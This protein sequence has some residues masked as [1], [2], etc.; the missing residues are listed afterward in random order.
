MKKLHS[1][2]TS[3][4]WRR[5]FALLCGGLIC[6]TLWAEAEQTE[7]AGKVIRLHVLANS[8]SQADQDLKLQVR[9]RIL[10]QT[11]ELLDG[12]ENAQEAEAILAAN[13][14]P[15]AQAA[16]DEI[17]AQGYDYPVRVSL[18]DTWFP[19][20]QYEN[21]S[22]P[23]GTYRALRVVIGE[24]EGHNWWCVL[25]PSLCLSAV[26]ESSVTAAGLSGQDYALLTGESQPY[27]VKF[28]AVELWENCKHWLAER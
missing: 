17:V 11:A 2:F 8:D 10:E 18:E 25:F 4:P 13:L 24:G 6:V 20:R 7:L 5:V 21:V 23:A 12:R 28:K 19:T 3:F 1:A 22:L 9:D 15:L 14:Q 27:V 26:T 16:Y